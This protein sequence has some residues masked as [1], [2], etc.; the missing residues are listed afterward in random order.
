MVIE[1]PY[2]R[3][4]YHEPITLFENEYSKNIS[5]Y[6]FY[7]SFE[8][9]AVTENR[10]YTPSSEKKYKRNIGNECAVPVSSQ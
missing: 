10:T 8:N 7:F 4:G 6:T 3:D 2:I 5:Y 1:C 9:S